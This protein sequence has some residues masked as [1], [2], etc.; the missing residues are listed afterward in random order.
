[1]LLDILP[2]GSAEA[3]ASVAFIEQC[4]D[5]SS[6][7]IV[8]FLHQQVSPR[9]RLQSG[10]GPRRGSFVVTFPSSNSASFSGR[11]IPAR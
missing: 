10:H 5:G 7:T 3:P 8:I 1:M 11:L 4:Q 9:H 6:E 2:S